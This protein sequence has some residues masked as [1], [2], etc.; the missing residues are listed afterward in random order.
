M[1]R[2]ITLIMCVLFAGYVAVLRADTDNEA[3]KKKL[4]SINGQVE[5]INTKLQNLKQEKKSILND[6]YDIELRYEKEIIES[7]KVKL[8]LTDTRRKINQREKEK[9]SLER[10]IEKSRKNLEKIIRILYKLGGN[11]YLKIFIRVNTIDQLFKNYR[12]FMTLIEY[13]SKEIDKIK[14]NIARLNNVKEQLQKEYSNLK[15]FSDLKVQKIRNISGL[16]RGKLNLINRINNDKNDYVRLLDELKLEAAQLDKVLS[17][18]KVKSSL[19]VL[20]QK[21]IKGHLRWPIDGKVISSFGKKRST[22]FNTYI[23]DN[24]IEIKPGGSDRVKAVFSGEVIFADYYKGYGNL[25]IIQHSR[26][27]HSL[28]G[29]CKELLKKKGDNILAGEEIAVVGD[30]G[31]TYGKSLYFEIRNNVKAQ[32]PLA[33]LRKKR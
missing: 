21:K 8:Q 18:K 17:G 7:N 12:L 30:T 27:I 6:I 9:K 25:I 13:K 15:T 11:S 10:E 3:F 29:H 23:V 5:A 28:Y 31:S 26:D 1:K 22:R 32:D 33:W 16:K 20:D 4:D 24:G 19:I 2:T 14:K